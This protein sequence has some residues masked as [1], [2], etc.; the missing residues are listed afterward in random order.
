MQIGKH[1]KPLRILG[2]CKTW[3]RIPLLCDESG[4]VVWSEAENDNG[5]LVAL[6]NSAIVTKQAG[7]MERR[8]G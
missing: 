2:N 8:L 4:V 6:I 7:V 1:R 3:P 5:A